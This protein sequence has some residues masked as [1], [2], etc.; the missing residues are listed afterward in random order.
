[1]D[2]KHPKYP[3]WKELFKERIKRLSRLQKNCISTKIVDAD[4]LTLSADAETGLLTTAL[5]HAH[6]PPGAQE[7]RVCINGFGKN[8]LTTT[9]TKKAIQAAES[10]QLLPLGNECIVSYFEVLIADAGQLG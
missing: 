3:T 1:M 9:K 7:V 10:I 8:P 2:I 6:V 4:F 5:F